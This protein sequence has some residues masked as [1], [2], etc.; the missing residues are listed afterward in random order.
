MSLLHDIH[1]EHL[2]QYVERTLSPAQIAGIYSRTVP[3]VRRTL[4]KRNP[5]PAHYS[6]QKRTLTEARKAFRD[7]LATQIPKEVSFKQALE[8]AHC[9][10]RTM[11]RHLAKVRKS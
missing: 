10:A 8:I 3:Y 1:P 7:H 9:S 4:P 2:K 5:P 11:Y 6:V